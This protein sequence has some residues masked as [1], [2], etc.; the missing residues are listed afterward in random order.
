MAVVPHLRAREGLYDSEAQGFQP[1]VSKP[2]RRGR[3]LE[4]YQVGFE[5]R[6][7]WD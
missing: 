6:Y 3:K 7:V 2:K 4:R 5:E 1:W